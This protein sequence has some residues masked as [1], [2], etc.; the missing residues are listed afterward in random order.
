M[1]P[2]FAYSWYPVHTCY[3]PTLKLPALS[4][5]PSWPV[6]R[7]LTHTVSTELPPSHSRFFPPYSA[8]PQERPRCPL[9][10][11]C[12]NTT[13]RPPLE[14][15]RPSCYTRFLLRALNG[16]HRH[17]HALRP[18]SSD[19]SIR[20]CRPTPLCSIMIETVVLVACHTTCAV[21][22]V[23]SAPYTYEML[24]AYSVPKSKRY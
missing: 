6:R 8:H 5:S 24:R 14:L 11:T 23:P 13:H 19:M 15:A 18:D 21:L 17:A 1:E 2:G 3:S 9:T 10:G 16:P 4:I 22:L 7:A 12:S 20:K